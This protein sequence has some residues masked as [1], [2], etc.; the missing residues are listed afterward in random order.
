MSRAKSAAVVLAAQYDPRAVVAAMPASSRRFFETDHPR[1]LPDAE[2]AQWA[3]LEAALLRDLAFATGGAYVPVGTGTVDMAT[4]YAERIEP[5]A[6][7][8]F[9]TASRKHRTPRYQWF[10]GLA[11]VLLL[12]ESFIGVSRR[13]SP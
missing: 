9:E 3:W 5:M 4:I 10:A 11:L 8:E 1:L 2:A 6:K 7:R 13:P 12:V